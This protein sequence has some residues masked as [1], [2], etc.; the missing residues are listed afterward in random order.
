M[1]RQHQGMDRPGVRQI[2]EGSGEQEKMEKTGCKII[3][4]APTTLAAKELMMMMMV[5][6]ID[7]DTGR[8]RAKTRTYRAFTAPDF[9]GPVQQETPNK[10]F[11]I[12][13]KFYCRG[14]CR[15]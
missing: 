8:C 6:N 14:R 4:G 1:G 9:E 3:C 7:T 15:K 10:L 11:V 13:N 5:M 12:A 2:P